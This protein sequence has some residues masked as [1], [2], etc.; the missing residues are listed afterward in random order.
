MEEQDWR[1][2]VPYPPDDR[3]HHSDREPP[4][5]SPFISHLSNRLLVIV[6]GQQFWLEAEQG[7]ATERSD[8]VEPFVPEESWTYI[9][10]WNPDGERHTLGENLAFHAALREIAEDRGWRFH[11]AVTVGRMGEWFEQG[12]VILDLDPAEAEAL[13]WKLEQEAFIRVDVAGWTVV[14]RYEREI[15]ATEPALR[16][17]RTEPLC[18]M[19]LLGAPAKVCS[20]EGGPWTS[21]SIS[22]FHI[23]KWHRSVALAVVGCPL[24]DDGNGPIRFLGSDVV[25]QGNGPTIGAREVYIASRFGG[26]CFGRRTLMPGGEPPGG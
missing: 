25:I 4:S 19:R 13:I 22:A 24:C 16:I 11:E 21:G 5:E 8:A 6:N 17:L 26:Y 23:W 10:A 15:P 3:A 20:P 2:R 14:P 7:Q 9:S 18:P 1:V 12:L